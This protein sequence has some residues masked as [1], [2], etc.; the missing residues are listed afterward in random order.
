[1]RIW[2]GW[3]SANGIPLSAILRGPPNRSMGNIF[4]GTLQ[5]LDNTPAIMSGCNTAKKKSGQCS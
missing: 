1:M 3:I 5:C 4:S 2:N